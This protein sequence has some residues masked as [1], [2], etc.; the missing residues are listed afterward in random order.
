MNIQ[1]KYNNP[2]M[3]VDTNTHSSYN[4]FTTDTHNFLNSDTQKSI[5]TKQI[6]L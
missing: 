6:Q 3:F 4:Y 2:N 5:K 1:I